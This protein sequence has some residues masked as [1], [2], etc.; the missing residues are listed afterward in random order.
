MTMRLECRSERM[1]LT[2]DRLNT[3]VFRST[4]HWEIQISY[5]SKA[6]PSLAE[7]VHLSTYDGFGIGDLVSAFFDFNV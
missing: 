6:V 7:I 2:K 3:N 1:G 5:T 4:G